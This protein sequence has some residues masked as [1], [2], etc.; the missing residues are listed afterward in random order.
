MIWLGEVA[1]C[2]AESEAEAEEAGAA[3]AGD[4]VPPAPPAPIE[5]VR[6]EAGL[7][8]RLPE[9]RP[10]EIAGE[11]AGE[12]VEEPCTAK[13]APAASA[14]R[15][16]AGMSEGVRSLGVAAGAPRTALTTAVAAMAAG[17]G[18]GFGS[19]AGTPKV[20]TLAATT[21]VW[22]AAVAAAATVALMAIGVASSARPSASKLS[23]TAVP[24]ANP[25]P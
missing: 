11:I 10:G 17:G 3:L 13:P 24:D 5:V 20:P 25:M 16:G 14:R 2:E 7:A 6:A 19:T 18:I 21:C 4:T 9:E 15:C 23:Y 22:D 1:D 12:I 8:A